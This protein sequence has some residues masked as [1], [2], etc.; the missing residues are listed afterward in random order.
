MTSIP[1]L[2]A[3]AP[4]LTWSPPVLAGLCTLLCADVQGG[5]CIHM[6][7]RSYIHCAYMY[8][9]IQYIYIFL[10]SYIYCTEH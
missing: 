10:H 6:G 4:S 8:I 3:V 1:D 9:Y 7:Y 2:A 5:V